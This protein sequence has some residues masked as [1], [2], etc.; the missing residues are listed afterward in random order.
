MTHSTASAA[1]ALQYGAAGT[2]TYV[3]STNSD[4]TS[5]HAEAIRKIAGDKPIR[6]ALD[7]ITDADSAALCFS[8]IARTGGRYSC[9]EQFRSE[10]HTRRVISVKEVMGY[11]MLGYHIDLGGTVSAY[12]REASEEAFDIGQRW[13]A[14]VQALVRR[15]LVKPHPIQE[16]PDKWGGI[17]AGL[18]M[19]QAGEVRGR[20][21]VVRM[22][23]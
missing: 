3:P 12:S 13:A 18:A 16:V 22:S 4:S 1:L 10:W 17:L 9:L 19:L 8:T 2:V 23:S 14:E 5:D 21:L 15:G 11:E 7:C 20:K 6:H